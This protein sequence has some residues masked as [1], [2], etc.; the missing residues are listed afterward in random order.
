MDPRAAG[1]GLGSPSR[2]ALLHT[3][4]A[5]LLLAQQVGC[6]LLVTVGGLQGGGAAAGRQAGGRSLFG[7]DACELCGCVLV[8]C[9]ATL[10][11]EQ[12]LRAGTELT[13]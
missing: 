7:R 10:F 8:G 2:R 12:P 3:A 11:M 6:M 9:A 4:L 5:T 13:D 1:P